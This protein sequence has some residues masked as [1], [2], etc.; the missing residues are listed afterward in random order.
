MFIIRLDKWSKTRAERICV[1]QI[2]AFKKNGS[3]RAQRKRRQVSSR[4]T[5]ATATCLAVLYS[6]QNEWQA[7]SSSPR[8][9]DDRRRYET[10]WVAGGGGN[11]VEAEET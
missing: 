6:Q 8:Q 11:S 2:D 10:V 4:G 1:Q 5:K 7:T 3:L 9:H